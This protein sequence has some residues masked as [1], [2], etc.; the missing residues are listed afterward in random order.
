M[1][2]HKI[3]N[4]YNLTMKDVRKLQVADRTKIKSPLFW[5]ND[6]IDA[7]CIS[8]STNAKCF[9]KGDFKEWVDVELIND[10]MQD[11]FWIGI[12][13]EDARAYAGKLRVSFSSYG[14]MCG[15]NFNRFYNPK[16]IENEQDLLIQEMF[17]KKLNYLISEGVLEISTKV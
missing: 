2:E 9:N 17:L 15:Y 14:G 12:Y 16:E 10:G 8:G 4:T 3:P 5:R 11:E 6:I 1:R 7:W 13:D